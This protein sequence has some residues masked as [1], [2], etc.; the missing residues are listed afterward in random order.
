MAL[1]STVIPV[2]NGEATIARAV[3]SALE[4]AFDDH[5]VIVVNDGSTDLGPSFPIAVFAQRLR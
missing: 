2:F 1:V 3:K 5:E 4:Q